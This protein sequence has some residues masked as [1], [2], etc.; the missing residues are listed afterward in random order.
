MRR[1]ISSTFRGVSIAR[2]STLPPAEAASDGSLSGPV[3]D[4]MSYGH[5][6]YSRPVPTLLLCDDNIHYEH[7][8]YKVRAIMLGSSL[9]RPFILY[10]TYCFPSLRRTIQCDDNRLR[11]ELIHAVRNVVAGAWHVPEPYLVPST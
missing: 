3:H 5:R 10:V 4:S 1:P 2:H 6:L 9:R 11:L 8:A 7:V